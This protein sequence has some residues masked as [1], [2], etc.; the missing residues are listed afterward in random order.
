[1]IIKGLLRREELASMPVPVYCSHVA[2]CRSVY[3]ESQ[4][5]APDPDDEDLDFNPV[6]RF[7]YKVVPSC[8]EERHYWELSDGTICPYYSPVVNDPSTSFTVG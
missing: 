2:Y 5:T 3:C 1:M 8:W 7:I 6:C 4:G